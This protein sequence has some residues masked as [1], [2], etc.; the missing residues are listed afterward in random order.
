MGCFNVS[1]AVSHITIHEGDRTFLFPLLPNINEY[2]YYLNKRRDDGTVTIGPASQYLHPDEHFI[3]FCFPIEGT[4]N[5]YGSLENIV[6]NENTKAIETFLGIT[7]EEF[8][9]LVTENRGKDVYDQYDTFYDVFFTKKELMNDT[10]DFEDFLIG[11]G[12]KENCAEYESPDGS[13]FVQKV[14]ENVYD[15]I[16]K[17]GNTKRLSIQ[18]RLKKNLLEIHKTLTGQYL[19]VENPNIVIMEKLSAM[20]VHGDIYDFLTKKE[21]SLKMKPEDIRISRYFL[22]QL[23]FSYTDEDMYEKDKITVHLDYKTQIKKDKATI[24]VYNCK[25]FIQAYEELTGIKCNISQMENMDNEDFRYEDMLIQYQDTIKLYEKM[26]E[27]ISILDE[28]WKKSL[29]GLYLFR[30]WK[31]FFPIYEKLLL[32]RS[33]KREYTDYVRFCSNS[34][35]VNTMFTPTF[36]GEQCGNLKKERDLLKTALNIVQQK[37]DYWY[38]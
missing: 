6:H 36:Q 13:Y 9:E 25:E 30:D 7:I 16:E 11:M 32:G 21:E 22:Q 8:I 28:H 4:Y 5:D 31:Y 26:A 14:T 18:S 37:I 27:H 19:G 35:S 15:I 12:F 23:G 24:E 38:D 20:F 1:C 2:N 29:I 17:D 34:Y 10:V 33:I 3:P